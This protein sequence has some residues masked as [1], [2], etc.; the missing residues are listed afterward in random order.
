MATDK[1]ITISEKDLEALIEQKVAEGTHGAA[2]IAAEA[3]RSVLGITNDQTNNEERVHAQL[4]TPVPDRKPQPTTHVKC[5][6]ERTGFRFTAVVVQSRTH[7]DGRVVNLIDCRYPDDIASR[8]KNIP[9]SNP[10]QS[11]DPTQPGKS[12]LTMQFLQWRYEAYDQAAR[13]QFVGESAK[14]LPR[15]DGPEGAPTPVDMGEIQRSYVG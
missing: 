6:D 2:R 1:T 11:A 3:M 8:A 15:I 13:R 10:K 5:F 9:V 12:G 14:Y 4:G 7:K